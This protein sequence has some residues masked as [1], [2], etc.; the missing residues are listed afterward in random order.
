MKR[1]VNN[2][3]F[4]RNHINIFLDTVP[5]YY[6]PD[7]HKLEVEVTSGSCLFKYDKVSSRKKSLMFIII[8]LH[9]YGTRPFED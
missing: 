2:T 3:S 5:D 7:L 6:N 1:C 4:L 8:V 9:Y